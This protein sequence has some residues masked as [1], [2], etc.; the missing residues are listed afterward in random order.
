M[1]RSVSRSYHTGR[2]LALALGATTL[3]PIAAVTFANLACFLQG[4]PC[5]NALLT[6]G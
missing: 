5:A 6:H 3:L 4:S 2:A 1:I